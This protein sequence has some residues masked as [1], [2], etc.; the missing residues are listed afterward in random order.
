MRQ[1]QGERRPVGRPPVPLDVIKFILMLR[2]KKLSYRQIAKMAKVSH[3]TARRYCMDDEWKK[4][5]S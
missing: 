5:L 4:L 1:P 3:E 2:E